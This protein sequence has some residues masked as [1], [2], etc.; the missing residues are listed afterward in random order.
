M[1][2]KQKIQF[3]VMRATL[4][5]LAKDYQTPNQLR[6]SAAKSYGLYYEEALEMSYEN[7]Q[8][9]AKTAVAGVKALV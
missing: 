2:Y 1:T 5:S 6:K 3:N 8:A 7:M 9:A 4:L